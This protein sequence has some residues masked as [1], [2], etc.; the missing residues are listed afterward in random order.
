MQTKTYQWDTEDA[1]NIPISFDIVVGGGGAKAPN[2]SEGSGSNGLNST[3]SAYSITTLLDTYTAGGGG[4][5][6]ISAGHI[7]IGGSGGG[8]AGATYA[9]SQIGNAGASNGG[10]TQNP[11]AYN[12]VNI[13]TGLGGLGGNLNQTFGGNTNGVGGFIKMVCTTY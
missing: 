6:T 1:S 13:V 5:G 8:I 11:N 7:Q 4:G 12:T 3:V 9:W 2:S 10:S